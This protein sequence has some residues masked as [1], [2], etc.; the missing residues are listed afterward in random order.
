MQPAGWVRGYIFVSVDRTAVV[1]ENNGSAYFIRKPVLLYRNDSIQSD[2]VLDIVYRIDPGWIYRGCINAAK[3]N[4]NKQ[5]DT[6]IFCAAWHVHRFVLGINRE[7][8]RDS[9]GISVVCFESF[10]IHKRKIE[11]KHMKR[12]VIYVHGKLEM[13]GRN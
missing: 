9:T 7:N 13:I 10:F 1:S 11:V 2:D 8:I 12:L 3:D 6:D 5:K 4:R